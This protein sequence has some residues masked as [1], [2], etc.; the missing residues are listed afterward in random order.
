VRKNIIYN[1]QALMIQLVLKIP[2]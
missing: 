1:W 2:T